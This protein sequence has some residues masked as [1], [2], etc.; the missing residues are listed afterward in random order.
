MADTSAQDPAVPETTAAEGEPAQATAGAEET[1]VESVTVSEEKP[2]ESDAE[3]PVQTESQKPAVES[4]QPTSASEEPPK[5]EP[6]VA[7]IDESKPSVLI[8]G[9]LGMQMSFTCSS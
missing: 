8:I 9:G 1:K 7:E 3:V 2:S 6:A 5:A 4:E